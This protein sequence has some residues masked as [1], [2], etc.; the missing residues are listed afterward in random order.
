M[1][2]LYLSY[3]SVEAYRDFDP[4]KYFSLDDALIPSDVFLVSDLTRTGLPGGE[5]RLRI[6]GV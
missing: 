2:Q 1:G 3:P 4:L 6:L 5:I